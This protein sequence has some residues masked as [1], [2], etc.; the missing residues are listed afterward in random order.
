MVKRHEVLALFSA[1]EEEIRIRFPVRSLRLFGSVARDE[2]TTTSDV[3]VLVDFQQPP[4]FSTY[5]DLRIYLE[6]LLGTRVD[7][8][9][10]S[11]LR[12]RVRPFVERDA[13]RVA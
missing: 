9:T 12:K 4:T 13:I 8:V 6:D 11:G 10:E 3:D 2:A 1:H 7:L 5:M